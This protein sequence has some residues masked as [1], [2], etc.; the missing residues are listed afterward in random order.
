M[1]TTYAIPNGSTAFA[2]T[3]YTGTGS[4][5]SVNN[6]VNGASFQPD[7]LWIKQRNNT[8]QHVLADSIRG[9]SKY[10]FSN[11]TNAEATANAGTG[12]TAFSSNGFTLGTETSTVGSVNEASGTGTYVGWQWKANGAAVTNTAGSIT[13]QVSANT[14]A[15]FSVVTYT[16]TGA[17]ATVGHGL[18]VAPSMI[19][20]KERNA[21][22]NWIAWTNYWTAPTQN[23]LYLNGTQG[24]FTTGANWLNSTTSTVFGIRGGQVTSGSAQ[25]VAYCFAAVPGYSAFGSYTGNGSTDGVFVYTGL[26]ARFLMIKRTDSSSGWVM[27]DTS[28]DPYNIVGNYL[29]ANSAAADA[30]PSSNVLDINSNGFKIRNTWTDINA[31]GGS[32]VYM[33]FAE[34]PFAYSNAR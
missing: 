14:T 12:I 25:I 2:A 26:R 24:I 34:T 11:L 21:V 1:P 23:G 27:L 28:R 7:F 18:G 29:Y 22:G 13:S 33:A 6:A 4:A 31:N 32:Y 3:T 20:L 15:G 19:I 10:I 17:N 30:G 8:S 5:M 16:G 9:V